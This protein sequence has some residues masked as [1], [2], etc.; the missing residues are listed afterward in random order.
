MIYKEFEKILAGRNHEQA[1]IPVSDLTFS[2]EFIKSCKIC[3][4]YN[5]RWNCP[6]VS[7]PKEVLQKKIKSFKQAFVFS[8]KHDVEDSFDF[9]AMWQRA[10]AIHR[11]IN[12]ELH[13]QYGK[14]NPVFGAG[15]CHICQECAY[16]EPCRNPDK[17]IPSLESAG[18]DV[19]ALS[20]AAKLR[21]DNG[22]NT[23]TFFSIVLFDN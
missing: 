1:I 20:K 21:Y 17:N 6:P 22:E 13:T 10:M 9:L 8:T 15:G 4:N 7:V 14:T 16:P 3:V 19:T 2:D 23:V 11:N 12:I 5:T 18:I